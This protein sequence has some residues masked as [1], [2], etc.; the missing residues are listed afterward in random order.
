MHNR[1]PIISTTILLL[2]SIFFVLS[3]FVFAADDI[4][5]SVND[6]FEKSIGTITF[7]WKTLIDK[8]VN[9]QET[10]KMKRS[11]IL[12]YCDVV[13]RQEHA[14]DGYNLEIHYQNYLYDPKQ[15]WFV[16]ALCVNID[17]Q[18]KWRKILWESYSYR[19][20]K[21]VF[22]TINYSPSGVSLQ[23]NKY[24]KKDV[25][26]NVDL[27]Q[28]PTQN[29]LDSTQSYHACNPTTSMQWCNLVSFLPDIFSLIMNEYSNINLWSLYGYQMIQAEKVDQL[30]NTK[31][32]SFKEV[33][34]KFSKTYFGDDR[35]DKVGNYIGDPN[36]PCNNPSIT[37]LDSSDPSGQSVH[38]AHPKT[39]EFVATTL[40]SAKRLIDK[41]KLID[42]PK[43]LEEPCQWNER[44][45][46]LM[47]C[48]FTTYGN[49]SFD[50]DI[51]SFN[52]LIL[53]ELLWY[54]LFTAYYTQMLI[55][56][57]S[58]YTLSMW[59]ISFTHQR[60]IKEYTTML[61]EQQ[62]AMQAVKQMSRMI[63]QVG[64]Y[65]P[66]HVWL[67]A[68]YEDLLNYRKTITRSYTPFH[69]LAYKRRNVQA[70][71]D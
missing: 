34:A 11:L 19:N 10:K 50:S 57:P 6:I 5:N 62:L 3:S 12:H 16:Y 52:N 44:N 46:L 63:S 69:Q 47:R 39:Y 2:W 36:V 15:S 45:L 25:D 51:K 17:E 24:I 35:Y 33:V 58:Y 65:F 48:A 53:N 20:Y 42:A 8:L 54:K 38:C 41:T 27:W 22:D 18:S 4:V 31:D 71:M 40:K 29:D 70:C 9:Q 28:I 60:W 30:G 49:T 32:P 1:K 26:L 23:M 67:S 43:V 56:D 7:D 64:V 61:Y 55:Y 59:S 37:Y 68:Y 66:L 13:L 14:K 21:S